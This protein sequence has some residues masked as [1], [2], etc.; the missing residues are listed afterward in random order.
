VDSVET[1][2]ARGRLIV[3]DIAGVGARLVVGDPTAAGDVIAARDVAASGAIAVDATAT[4]DTGLGVLLSSKSL[5]TKS[6]LVLLQIEVGTMSP[7]DVTF[8]SII[9]ISVFLGQTWS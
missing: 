3:P 9:V 1:A 6:F 7:T 4:G 2:G 5:M 8:W